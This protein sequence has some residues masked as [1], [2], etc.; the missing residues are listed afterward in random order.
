MQS[1]KHQKYI[2]RLAAVL[3]TTCLIGGMAPV[4]ADNESG[5]LSSEELIK[6]KA[7]LEL[8]NNKLGKFSKAKTQIKL[9]ESDEINIGPATDDKTTITLTSALVAEFAD[10]RDAIA[11][12]VARQ[13]AQQNQEPKQK[14]EKIKSPT[15]SKLMDM[16]GSAVNG[17]IDSKLNVSG[18]GQT[19]SE[20][21]NEII[22][23]VYSQS[24]EKAAAEASITWLVEAGYNPYG[25]VRAQQKLLTLSKAGRTGALDQVQRASED[26][27]AYLEALIDDNAKAKA[28][29]ADSKNPLW[30][31]AIGSRNT[32][33]GPAA[34]ATAQATNKIETTTAASANDEPIDGV[35][36]S[37]YAAIKNDV[38]F[39]GE[40]RALNKYNLTPEAFSTLD[41]QWT[42][43][44]TQDQSL[45][46]S[47]R[48]AVYY[49]EA[50]Q[51]EF[52]DWGKDVA[53]I[54]QTGRLQLGTDPTGVDDWITLHKAHKEASRGGPD[55]ATAFATTAKDKGL[56]IYDFNIINAWWSQRAKD[57]AVQGDKSLLQ[58][59]N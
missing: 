23:S 19:L 17:A 33:V 20:G 15:T 12:L 44:M 3:L 42:E 31:Q 28:L 16:L 52:A 4:L 41:R 50:S 39:I 8:I 6:A 21:S 36:L 40:G 56:S 54:K 34:A 30:P 48:Y 24:Q 25:A 32:G 47:K 43:R 5:K 22:S 29:G 1:K 9:V 11:S 46:L 58:R 57:L 37:R 45:D 10:D 53:Q 13:Q 27:V 49:L 38:A 55:T 14:T 26:K 35:S 59:M 7:S 18:A 51:G 2:S